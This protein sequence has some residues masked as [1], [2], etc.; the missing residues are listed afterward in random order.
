LLVPELCGAQ[1]S[2]SVQVVS[3]YRFR[4]VT[5]SNRDP[6]AQADVN[7]DASN[8]S[9][10]GLYS[11]AFLSTARLDY[12]VRSAT[13]WLPY[14]GYA[15]RLASGFSLDAGAEY[16]GFAGDPSLS[17]FEAHVGIANEDFAARIHYSPSYFHGG[18]HTLYAQLDA[19]RAAGERARV[20]VHAGA[21]ELVSSSQGDPGASQGQTDVRVGVSCRWG[22][23]RLQGAWVGV[24]RV[25]D[26][27]PVGNYDATVSS[28][29]SAWVL[30]IGATF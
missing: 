1:V 6:A 13:Q 12:P 30:Q 7:F 28:G 5:L 9:Y 23:L 22:Q 25:S 19:S 17:Y 4:G 29:R 27:Y 20:F 11:G 24:N 21:L 15:V 14:A 18:V 16:S 3:D 2:G 26:V 8:S 10:S